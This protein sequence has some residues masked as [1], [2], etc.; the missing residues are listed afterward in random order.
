MFYK[1]RLKNY[2]KGSDERTIEVTGR[3]ACITLI[4]GVFIFLIEMSVKVMVTKHLY[5]ITWEALLLL[6]M[7]V[8]FVI[9]YL[10]NKI[11][12]RK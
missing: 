11:P 10:L 7:I 6:V 3:T 8:I 2:S 9:I 5:E 12:I 1:K 4:I